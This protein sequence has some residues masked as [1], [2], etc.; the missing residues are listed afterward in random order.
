MQ[1]PEL[2]IKS[3]RCKKIGLAELKSVHVNDWNLNDEHLFPVFQAC[4]QLDMPIF[5]HPW[6]MMGQQ[7]ATLL[8]ALAGWYACRIISCNMFYDIWRS[9]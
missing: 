5:V 6:D 1:A 3:E 8:A 9:I 4:E 2:A 7:N